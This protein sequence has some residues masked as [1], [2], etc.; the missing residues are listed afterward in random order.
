[1]LVGASYPKILVL[2]GRKLLKVYELFTTSY[3]ASSGGLK[4]TLISL[5]PDLLTIN[6]SPHVHEHIQPLPYFFNANIS[7]LNQNYSCQFQIY[8][9]RLSVSSQNKC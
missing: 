8:V 2:F 3:K 6:S 9:S 5:A 1:M 7:E 4:D